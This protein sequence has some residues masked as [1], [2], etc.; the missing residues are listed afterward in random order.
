MSYNC[1]VLKM[2]LNSPVLF[3]LT[4]SIYVSCNCMVSYVLLYRVD[5]HE[6]GENQ[7]KGI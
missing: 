4:L 2:S 6:I 7:W 3:E 1:T 5:N